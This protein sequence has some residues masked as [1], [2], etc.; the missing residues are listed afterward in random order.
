MILN[1]Y[2]RDIENNKYCIAKLEK[3]EQ[4]YILIIDEDELKKAIR[5]GCNGIGNF[6]FLKSKYESEELFPFFKNRIPSKNHPKILDILKECGL[7]EY[8]EMKLLKLTKGKLQTDR[9][10]LIEE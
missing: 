5:K 3:N 4:K 7:E 1:L 2:W 8:D 9:Y 6:D 10:Y